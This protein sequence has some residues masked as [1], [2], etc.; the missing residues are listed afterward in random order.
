M[1]LLR[2]NSSNDVVVPPFEC[3]WLSDESLQL[4]DEAGSISFQVKGTGFSGNSAAG[5]DFPISMS[6]LLL[7]KNS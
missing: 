1:H 4:K 2:I 6:S 5:V 3:A 7:K